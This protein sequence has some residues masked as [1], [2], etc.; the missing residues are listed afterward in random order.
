MKAG[1]PPPCTRG[2]G[3]LRTRSFWAR[4][5][6]RRRRPSASDHRPMCACTCTKTCVRFFFP[7]SNFLLYDNGGHRPVTLQTS[8]RFRVVVTP[9]PSRL[10]NPRLRLSSRRPN[11][12]ATAAARAPR[13]VWALTPRGWRAAPARDRASRNRRAS[14]SRTQAPCSDRVPSR[15]CEAPTGSGT[16]PWET[17]RS[18]GTRSERSP[19][20]VPEAPPT[21]P[22]EG[23]GRRAP[24]PAHPRNRAT[25]PVCR[26]GCRRTG[27]GPA[28][29]RCPARTA[30]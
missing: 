14:C 4:W 3:T 20:S 30:G 19:I 8:G 6:R 9:A 29:E 13:S 21:A 2:S 15:S 27:P 24:R 12:S 1:S 5:R 10:R 18:P 25:R 28:C 26:R 22:C 17:V 16:S 7:D 23:P 11:P